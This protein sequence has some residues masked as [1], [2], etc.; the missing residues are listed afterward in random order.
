MCYTIVYG[1]VEVEY[2]EGYK[3]LLPPPLLAIVSTS[4]EAGC[5]ALLGRSTSSDVFTVVSIPFHSDDLAPQCRR[6]QF[7][8]LVDVHTW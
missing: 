7:R 1:I 3:Y 6:N 2:C 8:V 4:G 5:R